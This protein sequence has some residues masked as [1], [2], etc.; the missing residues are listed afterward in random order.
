M[1][2]FLPTKHEV[3]VAAEGEEVRANAGIAVS[4]VTRHTTALMA[5]GPIAVLFNFVII[6]SAPTR[7]ANFSIVTLVIPARGSVHFPRLRS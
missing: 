3:R 1:V 6:Y 4:K 5:P 2:T 7:E